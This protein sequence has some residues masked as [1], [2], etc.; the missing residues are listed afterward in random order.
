LEN[1]TDDELADR[2]FDRPHIVVINGMRKPRA[3]LFTDAEYR[4]HVRDLGDAYLADTPRH[5]AR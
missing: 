3:R 4:T 1:G 2:G 5:I